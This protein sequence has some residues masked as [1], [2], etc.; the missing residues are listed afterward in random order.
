MNVTVD[1][2]SLYYELHGAGEPILLVH[3]F[4]LSGELWRPLVP[5]LAD[6][7]RLIVP[8]LRGHGRSQ[9]SASAS[10]ARFADDLLALLECIDEA[11]PVVL[12]GMS[13]GGYVS[14]EFCR[15]HPER[16][17]ALVLANTRAQA[18]TPEGARTRRQTA[19]RVE[20]EGSLA[21]AD[22]MLPRLF[23][24]QAPQELKAEW[25]EIMAATPVE[26][27]VAALEGM[28]VRVD[29]FDTLASAAFPVLI[30]AGEEDVLTP[31]EDAR[32]MHEAASGSR[33]EV[34]AGAGHMSPVERPRNFLAALRGFLEGLPR[35]EGQGC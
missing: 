10:M 29:S 1:G 24:P 20:R 13:M 4:P 28:A 2:V 21:V 12:V 7:Y 11:R 17:R 5:S 3:G 18:D 31:V 34:L 8:D 26:G 27:I 25:H 15:R 14:F 22:A 33:L 6:A 23:G 35:E 9:A 19:R 16:V 30:V 32:R